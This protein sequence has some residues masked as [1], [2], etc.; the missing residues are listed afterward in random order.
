MTIT[1]RK[2]AI[3]LYLNRQHRNHHFVYE[4]VVHSYIYTVPTVRLEERFT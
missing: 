2:Q 1:I 4:K 3:K